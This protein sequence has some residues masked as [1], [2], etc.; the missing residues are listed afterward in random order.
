[1]KAVNRKKALSL[2]SLLMHG[3]TGLFV[4]LVLALLTACG[5]GG[6]GG[7]SDV[8]TGKFIDAPVQG[9]DYLTI[10]QSGTTNSQ[11]NFK[12]EAGED[13]TFSIGDV[14]L[15]TTLGKSI[16]T[17]LD[18]VP[19]AQ[20]ETDPT[21]T[22][23]LRLLQ[24]LDV[25]GDLDNSI[26]LTPQIASEV[27]GRPI[28]FN[29]SVE[30][31]GDGEIADLFDSLNDQGAFSGNTPRVLRGPEE[32]QEHFR[33]VLDEPADPTE[34][35]AIFS[36]TPEMVVVS[37]PVTFD[38]SKS[39]GAISEYLW[40]FGDGETDLGVEATHMFAETGSY[41]VTLTVVDESG[42]EASSAQE[43]I[44]SIPPNEPPIAEFTPKP[45]T[46][47]APILIS[48]VPTGSS[49]PD[50]EIVQYA[51]DFGDGKS[52]I[53]RVANHTY[54]E[55]GNYIA[56]LTVTDNEGA[57]AEKTF[58]VIIT[59]PPPNQAPTA[60]FSANPQT[61]E[62]P[63]Q[64]TF[65][66]SESS[67]PDGTIAS[68]SWDF[69]DGQT[70]TVTNPNHIY[71]EEGN[72]Q[73]T[74]TVTDNDGATGEVTQEIVV[75]PSTNKAPTAS[76][77]ASQTTGGVPLTVSFNAGS[78]SDPDGTIVSYSWDFGDSNSD[79]GVSPSHTFTTM[80]TFTVTLTVTDD[81]GASDETT[82]QIEVTEPVN[83]SPA[84][85]F[86]ASTLEGDVPLVVKFNAEAS[87]DP[88][89]TISEYHWNFGDGIATFGQRARHEFIT[90]GT[91]TVVLTVTD[92]EGARDTASRT[93]TVNKTFNQPPVASF[94]TTPDSGEAP[95]DVLFYG[96]ASSDPDGTIVQYRWNFGDGQTGSGYRVNHEYSTPG[97]YVARLTV[98][99]DDGD[100]G[101]TTKTINVAEQ[102]NQ[103]PTAFFTVTPNSGPAPLDVLLDATGSTDSDGSIT[104][105]F[106]E[107]GDG[108]TAATETVNYTFNVANTY[109]VRLTVTDDDGATN[110]NSLDISVTAPSTYSVSGTIQA[111]DNTAVDGDVNDPAAPNV[112]NDT[113]G[114]A[115][116]LSNPVILGGYAN[117]SN[118]A[119]DYFQVDLA[120]G[121]QVTLNFTEPT[122]D[123][124][125]FYE[126][127][128]TSEIGSSEGTT[129]TE[130]FS[131]PSN[132]SYIVYVQAYTGSSNYIL[133]IGQATTSG[134]I[135]SQA[136]NSLHLQS[137]FKPGDIIV[138][139]RE[140][141]RSG[142][143][144]SLAERAEATGLTVKAGRAG[145][146][147]LLKIDNYNRKQAFQTLGIT[148]KR[149]HP[150]RN[151]A[152]AVRQHKLDTIEAIK[153]LRKR[154]DVLYAE[155]NY[156]RR[157]L[158]VP[159]DAHY[160]LQWHY[161]FI[162][163]PQAWD[164]TTGNS[165]VVVAVIDTGVLVNH[166]DLQGQLTPGYDFISSPFN[167]N[168]GDGIDPNPDDT[169]DLSNPD[170]SSSFHGTHVAGTIA[171]RTNNSSGVAGIAWNSKVMPL[172]VIGLE[173]GWSFDIMEALQYA[174]GEANAS[175]TTP[176]NTA[177]II[178][179]SLGGPG[180]LQSEQNFY[181]ELH[182]VHSIIVIAAAGNSS[183]SILSYPASYDNV[184]SVSAVDM[185]TDLA[186]YSNF[187]TKID[188]AAP[189]GGDTPDLNGD[190][191]YDGV[192][193][194]VGDDSGVS[195][196][197]GYAFF[198][199]TSMAAPH[200]AG[201]AALMKAVYPGLT[202][203]EFDDL[204]AGGTIT[205]DL[206]SPG[207][208]NLFGYGLID[209]YQAVAAAEDLAGGGTS[210]PPTLVVNPASLNFGTSETSL[211]LSVQ[212]GGDGT[213]TVNTPTDDA[214]WLTVTGSGLGTYTANVNRT[215][216][217]DG[218][219]TATITFT[220][221]AN[222]VEVNV[223]MQVQTIAVTGDLGRLYVILV[224]PDTLETNPALQ[225]GVNASNGTYSFGIS[226][227]P[228][229]TY[230]LYAGSDRNNDSYICDDAE[231]CGAY[232]TLGEPTV[233]TIDSNKSGLN[234]TAQYNVNF[235]LGSQA[236]GSK[237]LKGFSIRRDTI[238]SI[239]Q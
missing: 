192:L 28:N 37:K 38:A 162:N 1:M 224:D 58:E 218:T 194:T 118:D 12:Y 22:N 123:L 176:N 82:T 52:I 93:I 230:Y 171:A 111:S 205:E 6:G 61:G 3:A 85:S 39:T 193:S 75:T 191:Y 122:S 209:A 7:G 170:G 114:T 210:S 161:P 31:F 34:L 98:T 226:N 217:T 138:R 181:N 54:K 144:K 104:Q 102:T 223:I 63:L 120:A 130:S 17:P 89:G 200:V 116:Q 106:W 66:G 152:D 156:L 207:R 136:I 77:T 213:L 180:A 84:A 20:D 166:P 189:G 72:Y 53:G 95:L 99:D 148:G 109:R 236:V 167:A 125:L 74:L 60:S 215:G 127:T 94:T 24:S 227:I 238:K 133:N 97:S 145:R 81:K 175:G 19:G 134:I 174:A 202:P 154:P 8:K 50:G 159:N 198:Q 211:S 141:A 147:M 5:G 185:N 221:S 90:H 179:L 195:I 23:I 70:G 160:G 25:D 83:Q 235:T 69:G 86:T 233:L 68:Y 197:Y 26:F 140:D 153:A 204:I 173:G 115:Q 46:G 142:G 49:D 219:Y 119:F 182:D 14:V 177:D 73:V 80:G 64:V 10:T 234:F 33:Q 158:R 201:V 168:D 214:T 11:G 172:R 96:A 117:S 163:L 220:S 105:Y 151:K 164:I 131:V 76:F 196:E 47:Q 155:P 228:A 108:Q 199:G 45:T 169:G 100:T 184:I 208:D 2:H 232:L 18:L 212:N 92:N 67:D 129:Q 44:V 107:L 178:N 27:S 229:G 65:N 29:T 41:M 137:E 103:P 71:T 62:A 124:D 21:V 88:D 187:G 206:G 40:D 188:L 87:S 4:L 113:E 79:T 56:K 9:L 110:S 15:G 16:I 132:G 165:S 216:L 237:N 13:I 35:A 149:T 139:F 32:A 128:D 51:W 30:N 43:I 42:K 143:L 48:F 112:S 231:A 157:P 126:N 186:Y 101:T 59:G 203:Q 135:A 57:T 36:V 190:G 222:T 121:Q 78:S 183:S 239:P 146:P 150:L 55:P 225:T 91:F